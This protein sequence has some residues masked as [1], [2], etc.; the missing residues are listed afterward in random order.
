MT[1]YERLTNNQIILMRS[2]LKRGGSVRP[3][4]IERWQR[5]LVVPLWRRELIEIWYK[6]SLESR[7]NAAFYSLTIMGAR[8][9]ESFF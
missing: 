5:K 4:S 6:Q 3:V 7:P 2:L 9:A 1:E 8:I